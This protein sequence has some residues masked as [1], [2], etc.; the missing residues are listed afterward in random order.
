MDIVTI[1]GLV[2]TPVIAILCFLLH[3]KKPDNTF[4]Y[5]GV[6]YV[7]YLLSYIIASSGPIASLIAV[8]VSL[9]LVAYL[10]IIFSLY[11]RLT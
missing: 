7:L 10:L 9:R 5:F 3:K 4:F 2:F 6:A 11:K 8:Q 1:M